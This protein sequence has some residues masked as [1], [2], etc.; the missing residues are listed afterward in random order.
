MT[1]LEYNA[2]QAKTLALVEGLRYIW[3]ERSWQKNEAQ[4]TLA[5]LY[6]K[7]VQV[8]PSW[9]D[10]YQEVEWIRCIVNR[11]E[12]YIDSGLFDNVQNYKIEARFY[13]NN[14]GGDVFPSI[15][16]AGYRSCRLTP[17]LAYD[18]LAATQKGHQWVGLRPETPTEITGLT[19]N[20]WY[21]GRSIYTGTSLSVQ[22]DDRQ[23][24]TVAA[25]VAYS[26]LRI[27]LLDNYDSPNSQDSPMLSPVAYIKIWQNDVLVAEFIP[28]YRRSDGAKGMY[29]IVRNQFFGNA[30][31]GDFEVGPDVN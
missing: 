10:G 15:T 3:T 17:S 9:R 11:R 14:N 7:P 21:I 26:G 22:V 27:T 18:Q 30:G 28:C 12:S 5:R 16:G 25:S 24:A 20:T 23:I 29:D 2:I 1:L 4:F 13:Y 8:E 19:Y 6:E 31:T